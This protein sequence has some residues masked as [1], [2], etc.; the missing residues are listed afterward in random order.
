V[1]R[2]IG[3]CRVEDCE[4]VGP[5]TKG[6]C[7]KHYRRVRLYGDINANFRD[8]GSPPCSVEGC[9]NVSRARTWCT[10]HYQMWQAHHDPLYVPPTKAERG[11]IPHGTPHGY[12]HYRCRCDICMSWKRAYHRA[13][14][15]GRYGLVE[16]DF[17]RMR[18]E[19]AGC[20]AVCDQP[21]QKFHIDHCHD[22]GKVRGLL[23]GPCNQG[24]GF[25][26]DN[27]DRLMAAAAY[28]LRHSDVLGAPR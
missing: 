10:K 3:V 6:L 9:D 20:C 22:T 8:T 13:N 2:N 28:L 27:P 5:R 12:N 1:N 16:A 19:Q 4:K 24:L 23:C 11:L 21:T 7:H 14:L 15:L 17:E 26:R 18:N 25:F